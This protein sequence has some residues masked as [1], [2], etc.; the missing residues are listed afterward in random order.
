[1][2]GDTKQ[3]GL[4]DPEI[5]YI[6]GAQAQDVGIF[7]TI[8]ART[9][10]DPM[11]LAHAVRSAVW[12][13]DPEQPVWK[14]RTQQSLIERS[15]GMPRFLAQLM[16][17]YALLALLLAAVGIYGVISYNVTQRT[18]EIGVRMALGAQSLDML[19]M[20]LHR[21]LL[22]TGIG[23]AIGLGGAL[24]LGRVVQ[25]MLF[26]THAADRVT[27][28]AMAVLLVAVG[29]LASYLPA[30]RAT[31]VDPLVALRYE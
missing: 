22:L 1:M 19:R 7:N 8:A 3:F 13:V 10:G 17:A 24:A 14:I 27:F 9:E 11:H 4:D 26:N 20:V 5:S 12:S 28:A 15:V 2:V 6:Y 23:L 16:A 30:R 18:H 29:L 31:R 25:S 21:A